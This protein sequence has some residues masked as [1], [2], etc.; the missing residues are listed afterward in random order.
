MRKLLLAG[1]AALGAT[2]GL[3]N[4]AQAQ[5]VVYSEVPTGAALPPAQ[6]FNRI[7]G[8]GGGQFPTSNQ[9]APGTM[10]VR[11]SG[12]MLFG[13]Q[14]TNQSDATSPTA[15]A[16]GGNKLANYTFYN[17]ARLYP[18]MQGKAANGLLYGAFGEIRSDNSKGAGG[19][20]FGSISGNANFRGSLYWRREFGYFG[21]PNLGLIRVGSGD[22]P[23][24][25]FETG[26]F[27][28]FDD[29]GWNG[30]LP[31][32]MPSA[33]A[34]Q[35]PFMDVGALY[36][37]SKVVYLSPQFAGFD[38][39]LSYEPDT[40]NLTDTSGCGNFNFQNPTGISAAGGG[41]SAGC[42]SLSSTTVVGEITRRRNTF[43]GVLRYR[44]AFGPVGVAVT[45]GGIDGGHVRWQGFLPPPTGNTTDLV[46]G[47]FGATATFYGISVGGHYSFGSWNPFNGFGAPFVGAKAGA[48]WAAGASYQPVP[49][50]I[51]GLQYIGMYGASH[52]NGV[53]FTTVGNERDTG[54]A[55]GATYTVTPGFNFFLSALWGQKQEGGFNFVTASTTSTGPVG[56]GLNALD[57]NKTSVTAIGLG[58]AFRW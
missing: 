3:A 19:G 52:Q 30:D 28:N 20:N 11:L 41:A 8:G 17:Y 39:G 50:F 49:Q 32:T 33:L 15:S 7:A 54:V 12:F 31:A 21:F 2:M 1:V 43:D 38:F 4:F 37:T 57:H 56:S 16:A 55:I 14:Y 18:S 34:V 47:D 10:I 36:T 9:P 53:N 22:Q 44:G 13:Q 24:S 26:T 5:T 23:T 35:W 40:G 58:E 51:M 25:L 6:P 46:I 29:G 27:E 42:D 48:A 45:G